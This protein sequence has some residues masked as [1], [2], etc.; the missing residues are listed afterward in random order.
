MYVPHITWDIHTPKYY[1]LFI[2][3][4]NFNWVPYIFSGNPASHETEMWGCITKK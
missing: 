4:S 2:Q 1:P 3:N